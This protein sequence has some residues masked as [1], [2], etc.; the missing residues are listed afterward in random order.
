MEVTF[1]DL[2]DIAVMAAY[3]TV[4]ICGAKWFVF[5]SWN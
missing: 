3:L 1:S 2:T 5:S 4:V